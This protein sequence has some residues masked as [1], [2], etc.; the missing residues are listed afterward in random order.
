MTAIYTGVRH[1][2]LNGLRWPCVDFKKSRIFINRS[3]T[4]LKGGSILERP[5]SKAA[6]RYIE[7]PPRLVSELRKWKL[8]CPPSQHGY[9]FCDILGRPLNRKSNNR[10]LK[11]TMERA[12]IRVLSMNNLRHSFASQHLIAGTPVLKVS[13]LMGHEDSGVT[14]AVYTRWCHREESNSGAVLDDRI[15]GGEKDEAATP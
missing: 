15:F 14:T 5:K 9:V 2:E 13:Y 4:E 7:I 3:L 10:T 11:A 12:K 1:G 6:Y 8:Q